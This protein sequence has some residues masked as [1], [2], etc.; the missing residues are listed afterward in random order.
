VTYQS[1]PPRVIASADPGREVAELRHVLGIVEEIAGRPA[2]GSEEGALDEAARISAAY[3]EAWPITQRRFDGLAA[4]TAAW[5]AVGVEALI[6]LEDRQRPTR[7]AA[8]R[9]AEELADA[10]KRLG[11][12][13]SA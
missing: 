11:A 3:A 4:E 1:A 7:P 6:A 10:L 9:L 5:A 8:A 13:L 12:I 2:S